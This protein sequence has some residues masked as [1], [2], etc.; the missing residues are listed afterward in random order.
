VG[1]DVITVIDSQPVKTFNDLVA[2]L[3][4]STSVGQSVTLTILRG[5][6]AQSIQ[7]TLAARPKTTAQALPRS[8]GDNIPTVPAIPS[9]DRPWL[10]ISGLALSSEINTALNLSANQPGVLIEQ[11]Q[12]NS[13][14]ATAGLQSS[15]KSVTIGGQS[16]FVGGDVITAID[17]QPI[18]SMQDLQMLILQDNVNQ[19]ITLTI[20]RDGK[21]LEVPVTLAARP[22]SIP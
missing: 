10:G 20:L 2:Y 21:S 11:V 8:N 15:T 17:Q 5:G 1:G 18:T 12:P 9:V 16:V 13:P 7:L 6:Q 22:T 3:A 19:K 14:A 4:R